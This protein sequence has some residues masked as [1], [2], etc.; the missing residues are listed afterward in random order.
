MFDQAWEETLMAIKIELGVVLLEGLYY[1]QL[2]KPAIMNDALALFPIGSGSSKKN[3][4]VTQ[5]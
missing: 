3:Q 1:R 4:R 5:S 2:D